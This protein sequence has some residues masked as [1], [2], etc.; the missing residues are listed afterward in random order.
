[1]VG[2]VLSVRQ[3]ECLISIWVEEEGEAVKSG[4]L[5]YVDSTPNCGGRGHRDALSDEGNVAV[6]RSRDAE[7]SQRQG[8]GAVLTPPRDKLLNLLNLPSTTTCEYRSNKT[9]LEAAASKEKE[10]TTTGAAAGAGT[11]G[12][13]GISGLPNGAGV[14]GTGNGYAAAPGGER[15]QRRTYHSNYNNHGHGHGQ[16]GNNRGERYNSH[17]DNG[18]RDREHGDED[19]SAGRDG[20]T[21]GPGQGFSRGQSYRYNRDNRDNNRD[22]RDRRDRDRPEDLTLGSEDASAS[23]SASASAGGANGGGKGSGAGAGAATVA[24]RAER[25]APLSART[26]TG[27]FGQFSHTPL[28]AGSGPGFGRTDRTDRTERGERGER[29]ER[30]AWVRPRAEL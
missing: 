26:S 3:L 23:I 21:H 6:E 4:A 24:E 19:A 10:P 8:R 1:M 27:R 25:P 5:R 30:G 9:M 18:D 16:H 13:D 22:A 28:A 29:A 12:S 11:I 15:E 2:I 20:Y 14:N 7:D 17:R